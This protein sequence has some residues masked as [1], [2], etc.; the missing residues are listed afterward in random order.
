MMWRCFFW[1]PGTQVRFLT[2]LDW[3]KNDTSWPELPTRDG[4]TGEAYRRRT[5]RQIW[6]AGDF[7]A[8]CV[9]KGQ[10]NHRLSL[11]TEQHESD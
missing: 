10:P 8:H 1:T 9:V 6:I 2:V 5:D 11:R 4:K 3:G 7:V